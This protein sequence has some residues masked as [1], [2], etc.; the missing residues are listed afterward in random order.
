MANIASSFGTIPSTSLP[1]CPFSA[2]LKIHFVQETIFKL[3]ERGKSDPPFSY[4]CE[5][6]TLNNRQLLVFVLGSWICHLLSLRDL[7][8]V[9]VMK[10]TSWGAED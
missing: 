3:I 10:P 1:N 5:Q 8:E 7:E 2:Q 6:V 9:G 4:Q